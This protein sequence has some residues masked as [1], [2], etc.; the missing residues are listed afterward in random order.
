MERS[1][2]LGL[3]AKGFAVKSIELGN[4]SSDNISVVAEKA[5]L[6]RILI[7]DVFEWK[8]DIYTRLTLHYDLRL[9]VYDELGELL[10][11][12]ALADVKAV[13]GAKIGSKNSPTVQAEFERLIGQLFRSPAIKGAFEEN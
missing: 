7:L 2:A 11:E 8:S 4:G 13:G 6:T 12:D 10:G 3:K 1:I 9:R 5:G